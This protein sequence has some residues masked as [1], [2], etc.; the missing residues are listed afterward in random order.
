MSLK[1]VCTTSFFL[2]A[3]FP[4]LLMAEQFQGKTINYSSPDGVTEQC[5]A[6]PSMPGAI[7]RPQD[8][9]LEQEYCGIDLYDAN[10]ALCPKIWSTSPGTIIYDLSPGSFAGKVKTF[11]QTICKDAKGAKKQPVKKL[12]KFKS[13]NRLV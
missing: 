13:T 9:S 1:T 5:I 7:S 12:A 11:E 6:L 4:L 3:A 2:V 8:R 10:T